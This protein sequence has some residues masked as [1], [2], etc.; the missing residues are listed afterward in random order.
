MNATLLYWFAL[1]ATVA[2]GALVTLVL[3]KVIGLVKGFPTTDAKGAAFVV[4]F[5]TAAFAGIAMMVAGRN[6]PDGT[7]FLFA[8]IL[9]GG[10]IQVWQY[11]GKR[12]TEW[13]PSQPVVDATTTKPVDPT[14]PKVHPEVTHPEGAPP[15]NAVVVPKGPAFG[16]KSQ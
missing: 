13:Q 3:S 11:I 8:F 5:T 2:V 7:E 4:T 1:L 15:V 16:G 6:F 10:G 12:K 9:G 14:P